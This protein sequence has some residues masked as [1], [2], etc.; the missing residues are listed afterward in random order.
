MLQ[1][2]RLPLSGD[3]TSD[4]VVTFPDQSMTVAGTS[5]PSTENK[6]YADPRFADGTDITKR[7]EVDLSEM[8]GFINTIH[9]RIKI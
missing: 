4:R 9:S 3:V 8:P 7:V 5:L 2:Q 1:H 6:D